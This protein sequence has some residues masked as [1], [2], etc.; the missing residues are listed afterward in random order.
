M[1]TE[2]PLDQFTID[3]EEQASSMSGNSPIKEKEVVPSSSRV[4][5]KEKSVV[6]PVDPPGVKFSFRTFF[7]YTG[8]GWLMSLAYLDPGNLEA[9]L[10][11]G[12]FT[13][14]QMLWV[15]LLAHIF[16]LLLQVL[17]C[18]IAAVTG[19]HLA[20]HCRARYP[21]STATV[22]WIMAE[23]AIIGS[24]IQEVLGTAIAFRVLLNIPLWA[25]TLITAVDTLT[26]LTLHLF[27]GIRVLEA[28]IFVLILTMMICFFVD[29]GISAPPAEDIFKGFIPL[30][31]S[32]A[33]MQMVGLIGAVIMPHNLYLHSALTRSRQIDR[34]EE[35]NIKQA[36][37]YFLIDSTSS[38]SV[39]FLINLAVVSAFA[40]G[41]FSRQCAT[42]QNGPLACLASP[43]DWDSSVCSPSDPACQCHT[44]EGMAGVC[45]NIGLENAAGALAAVMYSSGVKYIFAVGVLAAG[46]ASTLTGT[47]AGQYVMEGFMQWQIP[48]WVRVLITRSIALGPA[49][50]FAILQ[51]EITAMNG[52]NAWLNILQSIQLPFALLPV[53]HFSMSR[54]VMGRFAI[55]HVWTSIMWML[56]CLVIGVNFYLIIE[57]L[58]PLGWPW[59]A[60][61]IIGIVAFL[62]IRLCIACV[63]SELLS[64]LAKLKSYL[65]SAKRERAEEVG[66]A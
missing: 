60:W 14:Y 35:R 11:A 52:V 58:V 16:G 8:P 23:I 32:Y 56:A 48:M 4:F 17:A 65:R 28:F 2:K 6:I 34:S 33:V 31:A 41:M 25:G 63:K 44:P 50:A 57:T 53:L 36:N 12:A 45:S 39:S 15:L 59:Y 47:L 42:L 27:H 62:Y 54:E 5:G 51:G 22:L 3:T 49:L 1:S 61:A 13:G 37:K 19:V 20:E 43:E 26:F 9:D 30:V 55:G 40:H 46:Q 24:D 64:A 66:D 21:R 7:K 10:Q 29:M 18:R 38:L